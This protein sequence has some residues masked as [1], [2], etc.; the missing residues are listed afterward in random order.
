MV[1]ATPRKGRIRVTRSES[2]DDGGLDNNSSAEDGASRRALIA[3]CVANFGVQYV[4]HTK[5]TLL[6]NEKKCTLPNHRQ[7]A[8]FSFLC[9]PHTELYDPRGGAAVPRERGRR[10]RKVV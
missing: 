6:L 7:R 1:A 9:P 3:G 5:G 8:L 10:R 4:S 2:L